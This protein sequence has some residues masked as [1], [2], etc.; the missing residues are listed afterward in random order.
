MPTTSQGIFYPCADEVVDSADFA[1]N[2][3]T[4]EAA[5]SA[6]FAQSTPL[7]DREYVSTQATGPNTTVNVNTTI[8]WNTPSAQFNPNGMF[9]PGSPTVFTLQSSGSFLVTLHATNFSTPTTDTSMRAAILQAGIERAWAK[10]PEIGAFQVAGH[11]VG[12]TAGQQISVTWLWTG[13]GGPIQP[14]FDIQICKISD[15]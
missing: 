9:N 8:S 1:N 15:L 14:L 3:L 4:T 6:A 2:A 10:W 5:I 7:L 11:L 13:T 12:A